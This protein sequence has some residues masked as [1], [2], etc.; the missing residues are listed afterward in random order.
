MMPAG[1][2]PRKGGNLTPLSVVS[3]RPA[4]FRAPQPLTSAP[5]SRAPTASAMPV[6]SAQPAA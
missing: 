2:S 6:A 3:F 5:M 4:R 1:I